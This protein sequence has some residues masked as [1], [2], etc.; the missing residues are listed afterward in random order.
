MKQWSDTQ[1]LL[2]YTVFSSVHSIAPRRCIL[3]WFLL[4]ISINPVSSLCWTMLRTKQWLSMKQPA[5]YSSARWQ[6]RVLGDLFRLADFPS[7]GHPR[8]SASQCSIQHSSWPLL[9]VGRLTSGG[10]ITST[11]QLLHG[12]STSAQNSSFFLLLNHNFL[13]LSLSVCAVPSRNHSFVHLFP[14]CTDNCNCG[15]NCPKCEKDCKYASASASVQACR[16]LF[17][18]YRSLQLDFSLQT[19]HFGYDQSN[20]SSDFKDD[21]N[22][23]HCTT[24]SNYDL[25]I[26]CPVIVCFE[27]LGMNTVA[28]KLCMINWQLL[29][30]FDNWSWLQIQ[31]YILW[32]SLPV[33]LKASSRSP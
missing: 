6:P 13:S 18:L 1:W 24:N 32:K 31:S 20:A 4:K 17:C 25:S 3:V 30:G 8:L 16:R 10:Q 5:E 15:A 33:L 2:L 23:A 11:L 29:G 22:A 12:A 27:F 19:F 26:I 14:G 7:F 28:M 21:L 9:W